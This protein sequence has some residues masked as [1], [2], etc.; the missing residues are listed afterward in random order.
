MPI[1]ESL[2]IKNAPAL[3]AKIGMITNFAKALGPTRV[4]LGMGVNLMVAFGLL[5]DATTKK[6]DEIS[7][8]I[9]ELRDDVKKGF[10]SIK[11]H[12][13]IERALKHFLD[14]HD[15]LHAKVN[16]YEK[17]VVHEGITDA[18]VFYQLLE[19]MV[20]DYPPLEVITDL[21]QMHLLITGEAEFCDGRPLY[22]QLAEEGNELEGEEVDQFIFTLL[23]QFQTVICLEIRAICMLRSFITCEEADVKHSKR[24]Q[25]VFENLAQQIG[26]H[27]PFQ[28]YEWY[29]NFRAIGGTFLMSTRKWP[30]YYLYMSS[31]MNNLC[32]SQGSHEGD[33]G[34]FIITPCNDGT[35]LISPKKWSHYFISLSTARH[36]GN[37]VGVYLGDSASLSHV[38]VTVGDVMTLMMARLASFDVAGDDFRRDCWVF[39]TNVYLW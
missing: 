8:Q 26:K 15:K 21:Q 23:F 4:A 16:L 30:E 29:L 39:T 22:E 7:S 37:L 10:E 3:A 17:A 36:I 35:Y 2:L 5:E 24:L 13:K 32:A 25:A 34:I 20:K 12:L 19:D 11:K 14:I 6:L 33:R 31:F 1:P 27:D 38:P 18:D 9:K 28:S